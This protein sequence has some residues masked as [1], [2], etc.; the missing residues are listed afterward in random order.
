MPVARLTIHQAQGS[1]LMIGN[2][3]VNS[4]QSNPFSENKLGVQSCFHLPAPPVSTVISRRALLLSKDQRKQDSSGTVLTQS[5]GSPVFESLA[6]S[7]NLTGK[8]R[9]EMLFPATF[10]ERFPRWIGLAHKSNG[11]F[12]AVL[13]GL[14]CQPAVFI[15][16]HTGSPRI[17]CFLISCQPF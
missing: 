17:K 12:V 15:L 4:Q 2:P 5:R 14:L 16:P 6:L 1:D 9:A 11:I 8:I 10:F 13:N 7:A 3:G